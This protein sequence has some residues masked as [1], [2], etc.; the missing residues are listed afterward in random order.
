MSYI[1]AK[2]ISAYPWFVRLVLRRQI[3]KYGRVLAPSR[4]WGRLPGPFLAMLTA[5]GAFQHRRYPVDAALRSL[6]SIRVAQLNGCRFCIDLNAHSYLKASDAEEKAHEV[7]DWRESA[8]YS[9]RERAALDYAEQVTS[10]C[11]AIGPDTI[12]RLRKLFTEDEVTA[13]TAWISF[14]NMSAKFNA[15]LGAEEHGFCRVPG[16]GAEARTPEWLGGLPD[17]APENF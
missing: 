4:L 5:L 10:R 8:L 7:A 14:Q 17:A 11:E 9:D 12:S 3:R 15:A 13:L 2:P 6:V 1:P 16:G